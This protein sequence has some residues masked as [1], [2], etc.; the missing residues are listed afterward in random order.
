MRRLGN[1][2]KS[3]ELGDGVRAGDDFEA[4]HQWMRFASLLSAEVDLLPI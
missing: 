3:S 1:R 2:A 4:F